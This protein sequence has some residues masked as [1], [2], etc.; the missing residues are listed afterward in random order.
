MNIL[1]M[2]HFFVGFK[3]SEISSMSLFGH[4]PYSDNFTYTMYIYRY[5]II[6]MNYA[7]KCIINTSLYNYISVIVYNNLY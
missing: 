4:S 5:I 6:I 7:N 1:F 3:V 2:K